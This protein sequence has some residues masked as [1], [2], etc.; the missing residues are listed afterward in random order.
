MK[1]FLA[2][3]LSVIAITAA[4]P[5]SNAQAGGGV[6][7]LGDVTVVLGG[8]R[9]R[10]RYYNDCPPPPRRYYAPRYSECA[11]PPCRPRPRC[12]DGYGYGRRDSYYRNDYCDNRY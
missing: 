7:R 1:T 3:I 6:I 11:P 9:C 2:V 5:S 10:P 12:D 4:M 8:D